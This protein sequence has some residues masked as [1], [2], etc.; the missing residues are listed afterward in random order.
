MPTT[1]RRLMLTVLVVLISLIALNGNLVPIARSQTQTYT[2][3]NV[4]IVGGG[5]VP[6]I[7]FNQSE[8]GLVYARTDIG[9][10]YRQ[11]PVTKR[12]IP[13]LDSISWDD[14]NLTG[15]VSLATDSVN[16]N[17]V[18]LAAGT[19]TNA[20]TTQNGA[21][22]R[23][24]DKGTTWS[25]SNL[26]FKLGGNM[27]GRGMGER[28]VIDPNR[29]SI[30]YLGAPSGNGLWKSTDSGVTWSKV[31]NF[32]NPG[33]YVQDPSD[34]FGYLTD[35]Q[36]IVWVTFDKRTGSPG[37]ATQTIY[38]GVADL[39]NTVYRT[40]D[41]GASWQR[42]VG[43]PTGFIAH[44]GVLDTTNGLLYIA[45]SDKGGPYDGSH[46]DVW[47]YNTATGVWTMISPVP[48]SPDPN[49]DNYFGYAG[50]S[51]D[52]QSPNIVMVSAYSSWWPD[53]II[54][55]S[56]DSGATWSKIWN[57]TR[58]PNRSFRYVQDITAAPWLRF[59][60]APICGG[61]R[62]GAE[63]NPKLGWMTETL[64][65]DPFNSNRFMY[66]TGATIYGSENL[67]VWDQGTTSQITI[68]VMAQGL[69]ETA[70]LD[71]ISPPSGAPLLSAVGDI[72]GFRHDNLDVV[73]ATMYPYLTSTTSID[74]AEL[75]PSYIVRVGNGDTANCEQSGAISTDG[76]N[77]WS[78][79]MS[80]PAALTGGGNVAVSAT[81]GGRIVWS[82]DGT[83]VYY[84]TN[85]GGAWTASTGIAAGAL[86]KSD[87]LNPNKFYGFKD[88]VF[89]VS[90]NGGVS[91]TATGATGLPSQGSVRFK[92]VPGLEGD[93]WLAGGAENNTYGLWHSVDSGATFTKI[94]T[95]EE[96]DNI[97]FGKPAPGQSYVAL[98]S[99]AQ[100]FGVRGIYRSDD[101]GVSWVRINDDQHQYAFTG[102][103]ITGDP[104]VYGRVYFST[105]G[106]GII[107]GDLGGGGSC[108][109]SAT[110]VDSIVVTTVS[111]GGNKKKGQAT[112]T[113]KDNCGNSVANATV[114]GNFTGSINQT[115]SSV[116][117][118]S[119][120]ATLTT[121]NTT[122]GTVSITFCV[123]NVTHA[124]LS[125]DSAANVETC[126]HN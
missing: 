125:Y 83:G 65:I 75:S 55:R 57:W 35:N 95:V 7:I 78:K 103:A 74:F 80:Q 107:Y 105:N 60:N 33:N 64:E 123:T 12:W 118:A 90:T 86:V 43:Q 29:N 117:N 116:T 10:A 1:N 106:R 40:T 126:D 91:F 120:V 58:Y 6:G 44:K 124:T 62:P 45:T 39:Q 4:Q 66:G 23:S 41:G 2:F 50:L 111:G 8:S 42:L 82:P 81:G 88:G 14:W 93:V 96:A 69:E 112:V 99:S 97:G 94:T 59:P 36:G 34:P 37:N 18:Y 26:P 15:I 21:V 109:A 108:T 47:K 22:L 84:T 79:V 13:L 101:A 51:I 31:T 98:Y 113:I 5:F 16:T 53:T 73:P 54:W 25:R 61:G 68:K 102:A 110:H 77:T 32:P 114:T 87:R 119:G 89:Y 56:L 20:W 115:V 122:T 28:L 85:G 100:V 76:G 27:P 30:L 92:A 104:R 38:I 3:K 72:R 24:S 46:G 71:L 121:T 9:G 49:G 17:N 11:D 19:Y 70:V 48:S 63:V 52:R 67:T